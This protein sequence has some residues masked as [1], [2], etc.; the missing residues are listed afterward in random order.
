MVYDER[1]EEKTY[2]SQC[3]YEGG[4]VGADVDVWIHGDDLLDPGQ[5]EL[6]LARDLLSG[7]DCCGVVRHLYFRIRYNNGK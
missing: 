3:D 7:R 1:K 4:I 5:R 6:G 2:G